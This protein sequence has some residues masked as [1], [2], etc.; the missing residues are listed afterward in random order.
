ML[1]HFFNRATYSSSNNCCA[2]VSFSPI[3]CKPA[4]SCCLLSIF[5]LTLTQFLIG[6]NLI[7]K[8]AATGMNCLKACLKTDSYMVILGLD[9]SIFLVSG[10][11]EIL[12]SSPSMTSVVRTTYFCPFTGQVI[13]TKHNKINTIPSQPCNGSRSPTII[14]AS[15]AATTGSNSV[16]VIAVLAA[17]R[18]R[19]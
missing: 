12:G 4:C 11:L 7:R 15:A 8:R 13:H 17:M 18:A 1:F 9:P 19:P 6:H 16:S 14:T 5:F 10:R 2:V 3:C